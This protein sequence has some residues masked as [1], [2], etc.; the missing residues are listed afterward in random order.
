MLTNIFRVKVL[1]EADSNERNE[2]GAEEVL[3]SKSVRVM[4]T[5]EEKGSGAGL[6]SSLP[7]SIK[8]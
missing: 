3:K 4:I 8:D 7:I 2:Q 1:E 6:T 5:I